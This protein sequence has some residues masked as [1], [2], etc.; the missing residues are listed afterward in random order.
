MATGPLNGV[1]VLEYCSFIAGPHCAKMLADLGAEVLKIEAPEGDAARRMG[2][3]LRDEVNPECSGIFLY[4]NT[5]KKGITLNLESSKGREVF[6]QL[7]A[8]ADVLIEDTAPGTMEKLGLQYDVLKQLNLGLVM[9][10]ITPF[11]QFGPYCDYKAYNL[12]IYHSSGAGFVLPA[13]ST[14]A[15]REPIK[16][17]GYV[18]ETDIGACATVGILGALFWRAAGGTGQY[19]DIS[20]QEAEMAQERMN[21]V[22]YYM[23]GKDPSR[24]GINR[25]RDTMLECRD[26]GYVIV[27]LYPQKQWE[28]LVA[29]LGTPAWSQE[30]R[31]IG[32]KIR[33]EH[34]YEVRDLLREEAMKYDAMDLFARIQAK[35]TACSPVCSAEQNFNSPHTKARE[36]Y[37]E[38]DHPVAGKLMYPGLP[39]KFSKIKPMENHGAPTLGQSNEDVYGT[40][41]GYSKQDIVELK[42]AGVI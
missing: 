27:V 8:E 42:E 30:E 3:Y 29:A 25:V 5:N 36:F 32:Q 35:G 4:E 37:V 16:G 17:G 6:K 2:P 39:Y 41:L 14:N 20:R 31:F 40:K 1:K 34:F 21:I 13:A 18:G 11:G 7:T 24:V 9:A 10:S 38:I 26:G 22:R 12:N 15:D 28:G 23:M 33:D 19:I